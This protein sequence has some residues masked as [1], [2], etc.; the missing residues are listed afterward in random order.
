M[1]TLL[2]VLLGAAVVIGGIVAIALYATSGLPDAADKFL[3][4]IAANDYDGA[5]A[6]T[7]PDFRASTDRAALEAFARGNGIDGYKSASWSS[8]S[9]ENSVGTLEGEI[10]VADGGVIPMTIQLVKTDGEWRIQNLN[11]ASAGATTAPA[12][13]SKPEAPAAEEPAAAAEEPA[14]PGVDEQVQ[15]VATTLAA[16]AESVN[17]NDF[18]SLHALGSSAFQ[19]QLS[20]EKL[21]EAFAGFVEQEVDLTVLDGMTPAMD[22]SSGIDGNGVL[23]LKGGYATEPSRT[24]FE[25]QYVEEDGEWRL[26][27]IKVNVK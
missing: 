18:T 5:L 22:D 14:A 9:I 26:I 17:A 27:D 11:K 2:K 23:R 3:S 13:A 16:F 15:L 21:Q 24:S 6:L 19:E 25:L 8:R 12:P 7:T 10:T 20:P 4:K 1:K